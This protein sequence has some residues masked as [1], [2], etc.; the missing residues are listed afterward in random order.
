MKELKLWY[1]NETPFNGEERV[2]HNFTEIEN[3]GW[4]KWSLPIGNGYM[5]VNVFG[6]VQRERLQ[7]TENSL[8]NPYAKGCGGLNSFLDIYLEFPHSFKDCTHFERNLVLN[9]GTAHVIYENDGIK[10]EREYFTSYPDRVFVSHI[11]ASE[12]GA[13]S[14]KVCPEIPYI[15]DYLF[16]EG[17]GMGKSGEITVSDGTITASGIMDFY[18]IKFEAQIK[19]T[20]NGG[21]ITENSDSIEIKNADSVTL[22]TAVGT[23]Y[24][25]EQRVFD[26][27][28]PK[29]KLAPYPHPHSLVSGILENAVNKGY[30]ALKETHIKDF[31]SMLERCEF[32]VCADTADIPTDELINNY[33]AGKRSLYLEELYF[34]YGRYLLISS[35][36]P[37]TYP[38]NLQGTWNKYQ[39]APWSSGYWHNVNV[40][41]N[42]WPAFNT[43]LI[44]C[45]E[46]YAVYNKA[47]MGL[48]KK[49]A[50]NYIKAVFPEKYTQD[51]DNGW[52]ICTG[53][54]LY[55]LLED[56]PFGR[57]SGP[58]TGAF[59]SLL[60]WDYYAFSQNEEILKNIS[61]PVLEGASK[62][63]L[64]VTEKT[65]GL[66][67]TKYS[68]SPE[69]MHN[70]KHYQTV[71]CAFDQQ[72]IYENHTAVL[73]SAEILGISDDIT[74]GIKEQIDKLE[75]FL[76]GESGQI[77]EY[78]EE[79]KY[80][81]I[82]E[83]HH[84]HTSQLMSLYPG[85]GINSNTPEYL[86]AAKVTLNLRGDFTTGWG[87]AYRLNLWARTK[88]GNRSYMLL[89]S[90]LEKCTLPNLWDTHPPFQIDGNFGGTAGIAEMLLQSHEEYTDVLPA[91]PDEW[92]DGSFKGL[93][94]RGGF[95]VDA[96]WQDKKPKEITITS[97]AG[98]TCKVKGIFN[99]S[100]TDF[101][102]LDGFTIFETKKG[103]KY[104]LKPI[105]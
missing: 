98:K 94:A 93:T 47:Y 13:L 42:Y 95:T 73:K 86:E 81:D 68:A 10:Y 38:A 65:D 12:K 74:D 103:G 88:D 2:Q 83:Y 39:S 24:K 72:M 75:P 25:C 55:T 16:D 78:R 102:N 104:I 89:K 33:K 40:Q 6:R 46:P 21:E 90:L 69:Q 20:A 8:S 19:V 105:C 99:V 71:G 29:K 49:Q 30:K 82:G 84:R 85:T 3:D 76:I 64:K 22:I 5:G 92:K 52:T 62:F 28:D 97:N 4:E 14:L 54:W 35:S 51:G 11:K 17:D 59:T 66:Y 87:T 26:E 50:D 7:I 77:K 27:P 32:S 23:N 9:T 96:V 18:Q 80:G 101:K 63:L 48:A 36:R 100:D 79:K 70:G 91:I 61:Y 44:E 41:M 58:G 67:L 45:F 1:K 56:K 57:H 43:N 34:Q 37:N 60:F 31:S 53:A 15:C